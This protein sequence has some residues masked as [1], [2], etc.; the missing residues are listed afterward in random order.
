MTIA[1]AHIGMARACSYTSMCIY[2]AQGKVLSAVEPA[3]VVNVPACEGRAAMQK[4]ISVAR[5]LVSTS[6]VHARGACQLRSRPVRSRVHAR[7]FM[8]P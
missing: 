8:H 2:C 1:S 4:V 5:I 3:V 6:M 7:P